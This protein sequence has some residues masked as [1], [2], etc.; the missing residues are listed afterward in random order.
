MDYGLSSV[1]SDRLSNNARSPSAQSIN[2][3][4]LKHERM[5]APTALLC[6]IEFR[7]VK[8]RVWIEI[9]QPIDTRRF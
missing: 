2:T 4:T 3:G 6:G 7:F 5:T 8:L 1:S 9:N